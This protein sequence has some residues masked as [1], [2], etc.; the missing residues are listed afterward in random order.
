M[1]VFKKTWGN[2][3]SFKEET[4]KIVLLQVKGLIQ[5]IGK[6]MTEKYLCTFLSSNPNIHL[7]GTPSMLYTN[8][9]VALPTLKRSKLKFILLWTKVNW[10]VLQIAKVYFRYAIWFV[11]KKLLRGFFTVVVH[12]ITKS[13]SLNKQDIQKTCVLEFPILSTLKNYFHVYLWFL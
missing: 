7:R 9:C 4:E 11:L 2:N 13:Q 12:T 8:Y 10:H 3:I 1:V 5:I 6:F